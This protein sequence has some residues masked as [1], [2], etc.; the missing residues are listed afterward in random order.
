[1]KGIK[2]PAVSRSQQN[3]RESGRKGDGT[4]RMMMFDANG[5]EEKRGVGVKVKVKVKSESESERR[6]KG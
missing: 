5:G 6:G 3:E 2:V 4:R 1:M